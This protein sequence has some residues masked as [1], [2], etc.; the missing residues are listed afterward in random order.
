MSLMSRKY[1]NGV[2]ARLNFWPAYVDLMVVLALTALIA[3]STVENTPNLSA[4]N[5]RLKTENESFRKEN[6]RLRGRG[7]LDLPPCWSNVR[8]RPEYLFTIELYDY[9][10][11]AHRAWPDSREDDLFLT[12][13]KDFP[14]DRVV[15]NEKFQLSL[16]TFSQEADNQRCRH[17][18]RVKDKTSNK[19]SY[20]NQLRIIETYFH[21]YLEN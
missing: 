3:F 16:A 10:L 6:E 1:R 11:V 21:K 2:E 14:F 15:N 5:K 20:K 13:L 18:V 7:G 19:E 4:E 9:G 17:Y 12:K 8:G